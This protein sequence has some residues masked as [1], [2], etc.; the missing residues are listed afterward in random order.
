MLYLTT[1]TCSYVSHADKFCT[2][3]PSRLDPEPGKQQ[4]SVCCRWILWTD[5]QHPGCDSLWVGWLMHQMRTTLPLTWTDF[6]AIA[7]PG[8]QMA[9]MR[10]MWV[11]A[12]STGLARDTMPNS[13]RIT[14]RGCIVCL[15]PSQ[16]GHS[17]C[18]KRVL[19]QQCQTKLLFTRTACDSHLCR[20][21]LN[22]TQLTYRHSNCVVLY[23]GR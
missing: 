8:W 14:W 13:G 12:V 1:S 9:D 17:F 3:G 4:D 15:K 10:F 22:T 6:A 20:C 19:W 5:S 16:T 18:W 21:L 23:T 7:S 11:Y 2:F